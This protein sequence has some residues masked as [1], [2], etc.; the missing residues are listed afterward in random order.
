MTGDIGSIPIEIIL[1]IIAFGVPI[2]YFIVMVA[3]DAMSASKSLILYYESE[4]IARL[5]EQ[6]VHDGIIEIGKKSYYVDE[7]HPTLVQGE[8]HIVKPFRPFHVVRWNMVLPQTFDKDG[9]KTM[10]ATNMKNFME[11]K[12]LDQLLTPKGAGNFSILILII[13]VAI[14]GVVGFLIAQAHVFGPA[15]GAG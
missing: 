8:G 6:K 10:S 13:G 1:Y 4:K 3:R 14:G 9:I 2:G 11:N 5:I 12:A 7:A 15:A